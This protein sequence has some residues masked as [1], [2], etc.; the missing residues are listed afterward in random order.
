MCSVV[1]F[2]VVDGQITELCR[3]FNPKALK[4]ARVESD[5]DIL[6]F[7]KDGV[8]YRI[9]IEGGASLV[10][11]AAFNAGCEMTA[12]LN[13]PDLAFVTTSGALCVLMKCDGE[14][15]KL[16]EAMKRQFAGL[17]DLKI[18]DWRRVGRNGKFYPLGPFVDGDF[19]QSFMA[20]RTEQKE[21]I[22]RVVGM[23]EQDIETLVQAFVTRV[24]D[25][26]TRAQPSTFL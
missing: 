4:F 24:S 18:D 11:T 1:L 22:A 7:G 6:A 16:F 26:R 13:A 21:L 9:L 23:E 25:Y 15:L 2:T 14:M 20:L 10:T 3:D 17:G 5:T 19:V 12:I 8:I